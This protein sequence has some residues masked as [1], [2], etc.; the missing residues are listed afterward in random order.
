MERLAHG[1]LEPASNNEEIDMGK[2]GFVLAAW[3]DLLSGEDHVITELLPFLADVSPDL[4]P[5][6]V[7][8]KAGG[9]FPTWFPTLGLSVDFKH[10]P[11]PPTSSSSSSVDQYGIQ[12]R[13][14]GVYIRSYFLIEGRQDMT[15][16][17][18]TAP[19][20]IGKGVEEEGWIDRMY[21]MASVTQSAM[22]VPASVN[23]AKGRRLDSAP[24][25]HNVGV[26]KL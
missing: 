11:P 3:F 6:S 14:V 5:Q 22:T 25:Y 16:E 24:K 21:C 13:T 26:A 7:I 15:A 10:L 20:R 2:G 23:K 19:S 18:W 1:G 12:T 9:R 4:V 8:D 17:I